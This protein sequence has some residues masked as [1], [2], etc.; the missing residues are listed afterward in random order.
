MRISRVSGL[1]LALGL[2]A[3]VSAENWNEPAAVNPINRRAT[4]TFHVERIS[5]ATAT[6]TQ[7]ETTT[8]WKETTKTVYHSTVFVGPGF[9]ATTTVTVDGS[10]RPFPPIVF[11]PTQTA[12]SPTGSYAVDPIGTVT[13]APQASSIVV[14]PAN[15][16][17][18][19]LGP[20][21]RTHTSIVESTIGTDGDVFTWTGEAPSSTATKPAPTYTNF[22]NGSFP[23]P[24]SPA[25]NVS[26]PNGPITGGSQC[27]SAADRSIWC[28]GLSIND[29]TSTK[30][31][32][33]GNTCSYEFTI[34]NTTMDFDGSGPKMAF[35]INGQVPGP[36]IECNW[37]DLLVVTVHNQLTANSTSIHWHGLWQRGTNDQ[38][39]VPG[40]TE[41]GMAPGTS[42][43]YTMQLRQYGTGWYHAHTMTQYA[44]GVR[45]PM[46]IHGPATSNYDIDMGT[47]MIDDTFLDT[48]AQQNEL[49]SHVGPSGTQNY[50]LNGKNTM[51]DLSAGQ[52]A[53]W[54]VQSGKKHL[55]RLINSAAQNMWSVHL[56]DHKMTVMAIDYVPIVPYETEW[57]NIGIGQRYDVVVEMNQPAA[58]YFFRAV[59]QTGCPSSSVNTGLGAANGIILYDDVDPILPTSTYGDK[60]GADFAT[61]L[62]EPIASLVPFVK[63]SAG[64]SSAF[65]A[66]VSTLPAGNVARIASSQGGN[67]FRWYINSNAINV[68]YTQPTLE[69]LYEYGIGS[70]NNGSAPIANGTDTTNGTTTT[71]GTS[72]AVDP[73]QLISNSITLTAQ[74]QWVYFVI[75]NQFFAAHPMHLHGHDFSILGQGSTT[76]TSDLVS[77]LNF[78][79]P[80]RRD[81]AMLI[82]SEGPNKASGYTVIGFETDNPGAWLMHCHIVWH[83]D[84]GLALQWIERPAEIKP[85]AASDQFQSECDS[86][87]DWQRSNPLGIPAS[88]QSGLRRKRRA[89]FDVVRRGNSL[90]ESSGPG[91]LP[92]NFRRRIGD[93]FRHRH[94]H[95]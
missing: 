51:P 74:N 42:R 48:A 73:S 4:E 18:D 84:G 88:W 47:V 58:G 41:C 2:S 46:V 79:N 23:E 6:V 34:T 53:L 76:W 81:T 33:T 12:A 94:G 28:N 93:G 43:T 80:P 5:P 25:S 24:G 36:L 72:T 82:G 44:D 92:S 32:S 60:T 56:D 3:N 19:S 65:A 50:L 40:I 95:L 8:V 67:V 64:S 62:D 68:N 1:I 16:N 86:L 61:C 20:I 10:G 31:V 71:N 49:I 83:V 21:T 14:D 54:K 91:L 22:P 17:G 27:N 38:D 45:G 26:A 52:H 85:Y 59:T 70:G 69:T 57:L 90:S 15:T 87:S 13:D 75:Q 37:G 39:G 63:K 77:T 55:F 7:T 9:C 11:A 30:D 66:T 29:D 35:A 78:E 89:V